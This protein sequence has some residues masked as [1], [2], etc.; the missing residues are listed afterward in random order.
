M[1]PP[2][3]LLLLCLLSLG[4]RAQLSETFA[5]GD[6]T[7]NPTWTGD[8][9]GFVVAGQVLQ[10]NGPA[11]TGTQLQLATPCQASTGTTWEFW[12]NLKLATSAGNLADVWLMASQADLRSP[13]TKG[14]FVRLGGT[15]DEVSLFRKDSARTAAVVI[16][17]Q[18]GT[19]ASSTNNLVRV[20]VTRTLGGQWKLERDLTGGRT[21]VAEAAQPI[22][23]T[24]QRSAYF[25]VS[26]LYSAANSKKFF[27]DDFL[28]TDATPPLLL[29]ATALDART[30][31]VVFNEALEAAGAAQPARYQLAAGAVP[32]AAQPSALNP[33]VVRL[34][35]GQD[36]GA[37]NVLQVNGVAD[38]FGNV[39][40]GPLTASFGGVPVA[41]RVGELL[42]TEILA[43]ETPVVGLP[44]SEFVEI[45]NN[46]ATKTL[47]LKGVRLLKPGSPAAQ[48]PDTARLLP[49]QYA[50]VCATTRAAQFAP[51]GKVYGVSNFPALS[52]GGD[53]LVL[54]GL[55][56]T[57]LFE[58]SYSD[59]WYGDT[60]KKAG[61]WTLEMVDPANYCGGA[62][63]WRASQDPSGGTPG[64]RNSVAAPNPDRTAPALLRAAALGPRTIRLYFGEKLDSAASANSALYQVQASVAGTALGVQQVAPVGPDF[65]AVDLALSAALLPSQ[66]VGVAVA[67][68]TDC[69]GNASG[70]LAAA[71][72]ALPEVAQP[73]DLVVNEVLY[74][75]RPG[76]V[77]F[78]EVL[79][80]SLRY[81][82]LQGYQLR[83]ERSTGPASALI[84]LGAPYVLAPGQ[85]A[86]LTSDAGVLAAQYPS[87][88]DAANLLTISG[89]P[90]LDNKSGTIVLLDPLGAT[91]DRYAYADGQQLALL[92]STAGVS[93][94]RIRAAGPSAASNF[95]SAASAVGYATP[96][97]PN[98]QSQGATGGGQEWT[99]LPELFTPDE[100]GHDDF[101]TL[102]YQLDQP[103]YVASVTVYDALGQLTRRLLRN[104]SLPTSGFV[105]WDGLDERGHKA[106]VGYYVLYIE[107]F[108][109]SSGERR[110]YRKTVVVG[111]RL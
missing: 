96:G 83:A 74:N 97:R 39:A 2:Y 53:Q 68:A 58:V 105:Q 22:D 85:L 16:D 54:R 66:P 18:N 88:A 41:P 56:G 36:L 46:T 55:G 82:S 37:R 27:F 20:R 28:V 49:G 102:N 67:R 73:G 31:D 38:L 106:N 93:L 24:Y 99:V 1:K 13:A 17:G 94:E 86:A 111:A 5:D 26:L 34:T 14:Y 19:L 101:T 45:F 69:A 44:A 52:N 80:R 71:S 107:L 109:P 78:V 11:T 7:R 8:A 25:G 103:G 95:H 61:G 43:D 64:R 62:S 77:Y 42:I 100:D 6:F 50:V 33:A 23:Q 48:L 29:R 65:R 32:L 4:A 21:F 35:F 30:V 76:G 40:A 90:A 9:S 104:E 60:R 89:F 15:D 108:Q 63:N 81:V 59:D 110:E 10:S 87:S 84:S 98:S 47:S 12:V 70:A 57:T 75:H 92:S 91:I 79:N 72:L 3:L 51:Y